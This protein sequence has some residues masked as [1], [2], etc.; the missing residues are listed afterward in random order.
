MED[1]ES[2]SEKSGWQPLHLGVYQ[3][4][5]LIGIAPLYIKTHS[6]G[7]YVFDFAWANAYHQHGLEY[8][9]KL[10]NA[11]PFT[12]VTGDRIIF[13]EEYYSEQNLQKVIDFLTATTGRT[14]FIF[15]SLPIPHRYDRA[16]P[17]QKG[18]AP[19]ERLFNFNGLTVAIQIS[20]TT[21][22]VLPH[23]A[24]KV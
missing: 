11:I 2:V 23:V 14:W 6:Y 8:Y 7:E 20:I 22:P 17:C 13:D 19:R 10:V 9:P 5:I 16:K 12:P 15:T 24:V 1:S 21:S 18:K 4:Q 3:K